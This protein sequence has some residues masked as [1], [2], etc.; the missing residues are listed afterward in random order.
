MDVLHDI[1]MH[2]YRNLITPHNPPCKVNGTATDDSSILIEPFLGPDYVLTHLKAAPSK[3]LRTFSLWEDPVACSLG[4]GEEYENT[5]SMGQTSITPCCAPLGKLW[6]RNTNTHT[7][8]KLRDGLSQKLYFKTH[9]GGSMAVPGAH[10]L[11]SLKAQR[12]VQLHLKSVARHVRGRVRKEGGGG[13]CQSFW[14]GIPELF[15]TKTFFLPVPFFFS[16]TS[17]PPPQEQF[18]FALTAVAEEVNAILKA[19]PQ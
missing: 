15:N 19:L 10:A 5:R 3:L 18:E 12:V 13:S 1:R 11:P 9:L 14:N 16:P 7:K 6:V 17:F 4:R 8:R 2:K